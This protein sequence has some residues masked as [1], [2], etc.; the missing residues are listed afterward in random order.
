MNKVFALALLF[1]LSANVFS[2]EVDLED[3]EFKVLSWTGSTN[4]T[5][6]K[7]S[8]LALLPQIVSSAEDGKYVLFFI[9]N[10]SANVCD[11]LGVVEE[12]A[13][14]K[15]DDQPVQM[16]VSCY[17]NESSPFK[18]ATSVAVTDTGRA[19]VSNL[20]KRSTKLI[21]VTIEGDDTTL[22]V[23]ISAKGFSKAWNDVK[24]AL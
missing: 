24:T 15:F 3:D 23:P 2:S 1:L 14:W 5:Y 4:M 7:S 21:I 18:Y 6:V 11:R 16:A 9:K 20:L 10:V 19:Y 17:K 22:M 8:G 12:I 13:I